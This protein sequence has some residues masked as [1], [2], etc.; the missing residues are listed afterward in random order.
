ME[1]ARDGAT[2][3]ITGRWNKEAERVLEAGRVDGLD[4]NYAKGFK[5][6]DLAFMRPWPLKRLAILAR[7]VKDVTPIYAL[8]STLESLS[9]ECAPTVTIDLARLPSL[10]SLSAAWVQVRS[11]I[12]ELSALNDL[13]LL[14][15]SEVD[16]HPLRWN[17]GLVRLRLKDRPRLQSLAGLEAL[18]AIEHLGIYLA[19]LHDITAL[20]D[21]PPAR[22]RELH[23]ESCRTSDLTSVASARGLQL[24]NMSDCGEIE[25]LRPL[26]GLGDLE[27]LWLYGTT[28]V[29]DDD[30]TPIARLPRLRELRMMSRKTYRPSVEDVQTIISKRAGQ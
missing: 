20:E 23:L 17:S 13:F 19:P 25:S 15:Y 7:T 27:T 2:L 3:V 11:S 24:L 21:L 18:Q 14:S 26:G 12:G 22:L 30:L 16:L 28:K 10:R 4:L 1:Q 9:V 29:L 6:T 8:S 5:D